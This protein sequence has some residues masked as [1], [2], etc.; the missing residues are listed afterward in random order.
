MS[1]RSSTLYIG[2]TNDLLRRVLEH[3]QKLID[4]F[5]RRYNIDRLVYFESGGTIDSAIAR[6]KQ[7]K[8]WRR[9]RKIELIELVNPDWKDLS[10]DLIELPERT[11]STQ[12]PIIKRGIRVQRGERGDLPKRGG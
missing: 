10:L 4:G 7:I 2:V 11:P 9:E 12:K 5:T 8:G 1:N 6:E 3:K